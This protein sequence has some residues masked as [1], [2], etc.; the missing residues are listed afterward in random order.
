MWMAKWTVKQIY[1]SWYDLL[2]TNSIIQ[3]MKA[4]IK[5]DELELHIS[6]TTNKYNFLKINLVDFNPELE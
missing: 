2:Q 4:L 3:A 1:V 6:I 5:Q